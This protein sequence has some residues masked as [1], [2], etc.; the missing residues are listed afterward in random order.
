MSAGLFLFAAGG[1]L[2][3]YDWLRARRLPAPPV[4][5]QDE[6]LGVLDDDLLE[7]DQEL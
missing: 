5:A 6:P 2:S 3:G 4:P 1:S 7:D